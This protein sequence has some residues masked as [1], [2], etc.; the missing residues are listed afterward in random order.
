MPKIHDLKIL[1]AYFDDVAKGRKAFELRFDDRGYFEGD[2]LLLCEWENG[3]YTGRR[4][5]V[6]VTYILKGF[7]GLKDG[8]VI[9][10][11]KRVKGGLK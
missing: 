9:L 11:I 1:P 5:V 4:V 10:S 6:K 8:W 7:D 3:A 2:L